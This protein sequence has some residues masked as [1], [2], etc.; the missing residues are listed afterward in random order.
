[1]PKVKTKK[2]VKTTVSL[3]PDLL[4]WARANAGPGKRFYNLTHAVELGLQTL[5]ER[6]S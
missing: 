4:E 5:R 2:K 3:D 1:V 6:K